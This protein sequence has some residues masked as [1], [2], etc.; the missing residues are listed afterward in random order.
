MAKKI[1]IFD[2]FKNA[3]SLVGGKMWGL[4]TQSP[5]IYVWKQ[6]EPIPY[7]GWFEFP[8]SDK[9]GLGMPLFCVTVKD[10]F[11]QTRIKVEHL[12]ATVDHFRAFELALMTY[13]DTLDENKAKK[14]LTLSEDKISETRERLAKAINE[15]KT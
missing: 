10:C 9:E 13:A 14:C 2:Q 6:A 1:S 3:C 4:D 15:T 12:Q 8:N 11:D 5:R 7:S